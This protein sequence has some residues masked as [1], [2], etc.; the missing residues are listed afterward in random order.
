VDGTDA[1]QFISIAISDLYDI[2]SNKF[3]LFEVI[4]KYYD[5]FHYGKIIHESVWCVAHE[6]YAD[7]LEKE[8]VA[9]NKK[10]EVQQYKKKISA[11]KQ[12]LLFYLSYLKGKPQKE[13]SEIAAAVSSGIIKNLFFR[14]TVWKKFQE[15]SASES[16]NGEAGEKLRPESDPL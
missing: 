4:F 9:D 14:L 7:M 1:T 12:K 16:R 2:F 8:M 15:G 5:V 10:K 13:L 3:Y 11:V 6:Y